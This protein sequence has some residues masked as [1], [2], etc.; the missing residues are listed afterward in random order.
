M[1][2]VREFEQTSAAIHHPLPHRRFIHL[3]ECASRTL[4]RQEGRKKG[5]EEQGGAEENVV[6]MSGVAKREIN[7]NRARSFLR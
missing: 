6:A 4:V 7:R 3:C 2:G 1:D 5:L